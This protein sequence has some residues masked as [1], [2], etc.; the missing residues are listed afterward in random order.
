MICI[1]LKRY[2]ISGGKTNKKG[3]GK[4]LGKRPGKN[5]GIHWETQGKEGKH[6]KGRDC[7]QKERKKNYQRV[8]FVGLEVIRK[9]IVLTIWLVLGALPVGL[10][11]S[12]QINRLRAQILH[13]ASQA[14]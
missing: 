12:S 7:E 9:D 10:L 13:P 3:V 14:Q 5:T 4:A 2:Y 1:P 11:E 6:T 8:R